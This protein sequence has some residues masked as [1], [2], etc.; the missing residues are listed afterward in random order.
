[1]PQDCGLLLEIKG[2]IMKRNLLW[3][4]FSCFLVVV[5]LAF[6]NCNAKKFNATVESNVNGSMDT[7]DENG[8]IE[9]EVI[10]RSCQDE[11][12][13]CPNRVVIRLYAVVDGDRERIS[14]DAEAIAVEPGRYTFSYT[15]P[16]QYKCKQILAFVVD[17]IS[18]SEVQISLGSGFIYWGDVSTCPGLDD[19]D[20]DDP[21]GGVNPS[22]SINS[23]NTLGRV[24]ELKGSCSPDTAMTFTGDLLASAGL[25]GSCSG[26][27]FKYCGLLANHFT[28]N[29][30]TAEIR[31]NSN[32]ARD[33]ETIT[34]NSAPVAILT[35]DNVSVNEAMHTLSVNGRC[36]AGALLSL[37]FYNADIATNISCVGAGTWSYTGNVLVANAERILKVTQRTPFNV[38]SR[39][40]ARLNASNDSAGANENLACAI[41]STTATGALCSGQAGTITGSCQRGLPVFISVNNKFQTVAFCSDG[42]GSGGT[43]S[44][45][46]VLLEKT[47]MNNVIKIQQTNAYGRSCSSQVTKTT[48]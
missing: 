25:T 21:P 18:G 26:N 48:F 19:D 22:V 12:A 11:N 28:R 30:V 32:V 45:S 13:N 29:V 15:I 10:V 14:P 41:S 17:P 2:G 42:T 8:L 9:G 23:V 24:V 1:M 5:T 36:N 43:F 40:S 27:K 35:V 20:D 33:S 7:M 44:V 3:V 38:T 34:L 46:N 39:I 31:S 4:S 37:N 16:S 47:G 6:Q